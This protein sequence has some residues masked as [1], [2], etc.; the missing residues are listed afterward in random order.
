MRSPII[1]ALLI[2]L[3]TGIAPK[4]WPSQTGMPIF[5]SSVGEAQALPDH[6]VVYF[7]LT[8]YGASEAAG[9]AGRCGE[10]A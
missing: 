6:V 1:L 5:M 4:A 2:A 9:G 8:R 10:G 3:L 7:T